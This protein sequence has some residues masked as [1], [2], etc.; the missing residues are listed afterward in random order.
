MECEIKWML[1]FTTLF[2]LF[3]IMG[4]VSYNDLLTAA[5]THSILIPPHLNW[6]SDDYALIDVLQVEDIFYLN[7]DRT[8]HFLAFYHAPE[9]QDVDGHIRLA[10]YI[11]DFKVD[12]PIGAIIITLIKLLPS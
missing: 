3:L 7:D 12:S 5:D 11:S 4:C 10:E 2:L 6:Q 1:R 9:N 8:Q